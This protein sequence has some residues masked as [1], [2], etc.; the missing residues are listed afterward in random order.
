[1]STIPP[2]PDMLDAALLKLE[3]QG[4][5]TVSEIL[6]RRELRAQMKWGLPDGS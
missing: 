2:G 3:L 5:L 6:L 4:R 1:M